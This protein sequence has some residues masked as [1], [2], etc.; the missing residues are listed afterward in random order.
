MT[1][2]LRPETFCH[3][4]LRPTP[5]P[6][7]TGDVTSV[8]VIDMIALLHWDAVIDRHGTV[9]AMTCPDCLAGLRRG[10]VR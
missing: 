7:G 4:C 2:L 3:L 10:E 1:G 5:V 6:K 8:Q 9:L